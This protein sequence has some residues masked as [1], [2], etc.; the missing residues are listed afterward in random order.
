VSEKVWFVENQLPMELQPVF[1]QPSA[2]VQMS[3]LFARDL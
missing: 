1:L 3:E 2:E